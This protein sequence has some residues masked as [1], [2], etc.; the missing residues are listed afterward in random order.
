MAVIE[1]VETKLP[2]D[3]KFKRD[4]PLTSRLPFILRL[5]AMVEVAVVDVA[6]KK[7]NVGVE[8][9]TNR[10][11]ESVP[12]SELTGADTDHIGKPKV[13][14]ATQDELVPSVCKILPLEG[15]GAN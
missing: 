4:T 10:P 8:V 9:A 15:D 2:E 7:L 3:T 12:I 5:P 1:P 11:E 6:L 13:E 14:V